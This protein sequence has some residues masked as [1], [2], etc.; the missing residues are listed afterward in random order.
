MK[1]NIYY[2]LPSYNESL[3]LNKLLSDFKKFFEKKNITVIVVIVNDGS[4]DN[5]VS[6]INSFIK[7]NK[8]KNFTIKMI[9]HKK[10]MGLGRAL[11]TGFEYSFLKGK[12]NDVIVSMDTDNSHTVSLSY[13][14]AE[15]IFYKK[16]D[17]LIASRYQLSSK[18]K[19]LNYWRKSL[20]LGAAILYKIFFPIKN[21]KDYTSGFRAFRLG[22]IKKA[23]KK[24]KNFFSEKGFSAS[25]DIILKLYIY[26]KEIA[27][28]EV[29]INLRYDLKKGDSKMK[30]FKTIYL[31]LALIIKRK[32]L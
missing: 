17:I 28:L 22:V 21:I 7:K 1:K 25:A 11:K 5:S 2:V 9:E 4:T 13:K 8:S 15:N 19:G 27:F 31:N 32:F 23:W 14:M 10:N 30:I 18:I 6:I 29:P 3:N 24:N 20:S 12:Y 16:K 26:K